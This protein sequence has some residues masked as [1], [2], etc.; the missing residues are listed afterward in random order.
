MKKCRTR[1]QN[2]SGMSLVEI[3]VSLGILSIVMLA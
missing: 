1:F 2:E 3:L